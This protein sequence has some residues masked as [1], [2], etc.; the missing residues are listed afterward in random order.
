LCILT[1]DA[2][3]PNFPIAKNH[4]QLVGFVDAAHGNNLHHCCSTTGYFFMP[5]GGPI[6]YRSKTQTITATSLTEAEFVMAVTAAKVAK[7]LRYILAQLG[8]P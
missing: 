2:S 5:S 1:N 4:H 3:L 6:A 8:F 7:Y